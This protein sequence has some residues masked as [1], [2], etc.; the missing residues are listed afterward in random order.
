MP[1]QVK[2]LIVE[3][4]PIVL[5]ANTT[6]IKMAGYSFDASETSKKALKLAFKNPYD[7]IFMDLGLDEYMTGYQVAEKIRNENNPNQATP[8]VALTAHTEEEVREQ[9]LEVGMVDVLRKPIT[10]D[11]IK[12]VVQQY[13]LSQL[14]LVRK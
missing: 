12:T 1:N 10:V 14:K 9:C 4:N 11:T 7:L 5:L 3:D 2:I 8:I 6:L 13:V